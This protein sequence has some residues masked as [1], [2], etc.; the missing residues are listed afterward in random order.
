MRKIE[1]VKIILAASLF[2]GGSSSA[3][4]AKS[5]E[6]AMPEI[7][8]MFSDLEGKFSSEAKTEVS[9]LQ[10]CVKD[11][12]ICV[13]AKSINQ[14]G[15][16]IVGG[17]DPSDFESAGARSLIAVS[18]IADMSTPRGEHCILGRYSGGTATNW[19]VIGWGRQKGKLKVFRD[20]ELNLVGEFKS[21]ATLVN[22]LFMTGRKFH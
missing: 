10:N 12:R 18:A 6:T 15:F 3:Q 16:Q 2:T 7:R 4:A 11:H 13:V 17:N 9:L 22:E 14:S 1:L 21:P 19:M 20:P 5:C 8:N